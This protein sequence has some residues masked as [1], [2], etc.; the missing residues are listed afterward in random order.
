MNVASARMVVQ[1]RNH[2]IDQGVDPNTIKSVDHRK[3]HGETLG[4]I[5]DAYV[6]QHLSKRSKSHRA[7]F[8]RLIAPWIREEPK[9]PN[10]GGKRQTRLTIGQAFRETIAEEITPRHIGPYL[11]RIPSDS[12]A[13]SALRQLRALFNWAIRMQI[14]DMR[15]P[16]GPFEMRKIIK[17]RRDYTPEQVRLIAQRVFNPPMKAAISLEGLE[18]EKKRLAALQA[19]HAGREH[20]QL[21]ELCNFMGILFLTMA[22]PT[23]VKHARYEHFD[24]DRL[25]WHKHNTKGIK[26]SRTTYEYAFRSVP[27]HP[28]VG[29]LV[30]QQR[31]RWPDSGF[32]FP[33]HTDLTQPRDNFAR[34][35]KKFKG[36]EGIPAHFQLYDIKRMAISL[37]ITGQGVRR[38]DVSH[39]VDHRGNI[40]TTMIYDLGF[41][42]PLR[43]VTHKLG[44]LLGVD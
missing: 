33:N 38:E 26:L 14:V 16:C 10:R 24:L 32:V 34:A 40:D 17:Q 43:P 23:E 1:Q 5:I 13:N 8:G 36:L 30:Q 37:M 25:I 31:L 39:Y 27:I 2:E 9:N 20:D 21:L 41:V 22:R 44:E 7:E 12:V 15:N 29:E 3:K 19:G 11:Q 42:D 28:K 18:G 35:I 4:E 6:D